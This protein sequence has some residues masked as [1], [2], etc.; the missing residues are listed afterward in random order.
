M[1]RRNAVVN[2]WF[3]LVLVLFVGA[4]VLWPLPAPAETAPE[5]AYYKEGQT[6]QG[7]PYMTGGISVEERNAM[8]ERDD[9][10][11]L[12]LVF[13]E[14]SGVYLAGVPLTIMDR[15]G[16]EIAAITSEGP[17]FYIKLPPGTYHA[18]AMVDGE[19]RKIDLSVPD[20]G[21]VARIFHWDLESVPEVQL[22]GRP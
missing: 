15:N 17:W 13:A 14:K 16:K 21:A 5:A 22:A 6:P 20:S 11:N 18:S 4:A 1:E 10:Y 2:R 8:T 9:A 12:K 19:S 7:F 3:D